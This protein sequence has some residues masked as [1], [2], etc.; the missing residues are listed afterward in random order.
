MS[1]LINQ[2]MFDEAADFLAGA[3]WTFGYYR[4]KDKATGIEQWQA[5]AFKGK[6][7]FVVSGS[8][9]G[10]VLNQLKKLILEMN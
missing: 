5:D 6:T 9:L 8:I 3:G 7:R 1:E 10:E 4:T 2:S